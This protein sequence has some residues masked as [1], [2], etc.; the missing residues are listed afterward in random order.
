MSRERRHAMRRPD[1]FH[2]AARPAGAP[3]STLRSPRR[4]AP[5]SSHEKQFRPYPCI[6][7]LGS[8]RRC[9]GGARFLV[10]FPAQAAS[11]ET[12]YS[13]PHGH[14]L[15]RPEGHVKSAHAAAAII[16]PRAW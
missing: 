5:P 7:S 4:S 15:P 3:R 2:P 14:Q 12:E 6:R 1:I 16:H 8:P 10:N 9:R 13:S 11:I